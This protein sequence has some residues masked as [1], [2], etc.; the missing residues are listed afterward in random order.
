M[1]RR[2]DLGGGGVRG[3][4]G[5]GQRGASEG[6]VWEAA[7]ALGSHREVAAVTTAVMLEHMQ[8]RAH[9]YS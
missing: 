6:R 7:G 5:R 3:G 1:T 4:G 8:E 9:Q 2:G